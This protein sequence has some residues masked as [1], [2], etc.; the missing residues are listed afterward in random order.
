MYVSVAGA[1][2]LPDASGHFRVA[3][4]TA[5]ATAA[6]MPGGGRVAGKI[7]IISSFGNT[8]FLSIVGK[9]DLTEFTTSKIA[10][11]VFPVK[12]M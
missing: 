5:A 4:S 2:P 8:I 10:H 6:T 7:G 11:P 3:A 12:Q 1:C 9:R